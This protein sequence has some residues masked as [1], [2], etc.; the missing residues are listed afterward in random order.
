MQC[1]SKKIHCWKVKKIS[2]IVDLIEHNIDSNQDLLKGR[3]NEEDNHKMHTLVT[4][5]SN[6]INCIVHLT[7]VEI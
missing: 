2:F 7:I 3:H 5:F 6:F 1:C 4:N